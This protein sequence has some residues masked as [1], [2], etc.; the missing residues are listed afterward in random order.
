MAL[1]VSPGDPDSATKAFAEL[2]SKLDN[3]KIA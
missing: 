3:E 1:H 2:K